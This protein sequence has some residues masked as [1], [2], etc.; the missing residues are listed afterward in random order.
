MKKI[1]WVWLASLAGVLLYLFLTYNQLPDEVASHF[2]A[3]GTP[4]GFQ[5]KDGYL[6]FVL[7][8]MFLMNGLMGGLY[9]L[10][11]LVPASLIHVPRKDYWFSTPERIQELHQRFRGVAGILGIFLN[12][13]F[14]FAEQA[15]YQANVPD[16][17][18]RISIN[19]GVF[20]VLLG[21]LALAVFSFLL[22]RPPAED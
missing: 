4:N 21:G 7:G 17:P 3:A 2:D 9:F 15:V 1:T 13:V 11:A 22:F 10:L 19:G 6:S 12:L 8:F 18:F 20:F 5:T 14:L 16:A